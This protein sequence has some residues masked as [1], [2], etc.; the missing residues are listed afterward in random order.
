VIFRKTLYVLHTV[1]NI[2]PYW[3]VKFY[4]KI[5]SHA[6]IIL[7]CLSE[8]EEGAKTFLVN[9]IVLKLVGFV[10][11][12]FKVEDSNSSFTLLVVWMTQKVLVS[13]LLVGSLVWPI[14]NMLPIH[15]NKSYT[16]PLVLVIHMLKSN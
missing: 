13:C 1:T 4:K 3:L 9:Q 6:K 14:R 8:L 12:V 7:L 11:P 15:D 10:W 2:V 16:L 5:G